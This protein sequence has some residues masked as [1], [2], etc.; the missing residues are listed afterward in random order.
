M[1]HNLIESRNHILMNTPHLATTTG[2]MVT[3][4]TDLAA[5]LTSVKANFLPV[6]EGSGDP[7]PTNVR[8]ITGWTGIKVCRA[9]KN[10]LDPAVKSG[11]SYVLDECWFGSDYNNNSRQLPIGNLFLP[12]NNYVLST[13]G[14]PTEKRVNKYD[15]TIIGHAYGNS[16][17]LKFTTTEENNRNIACYISVNSNQS[18]T[19]KNETMIE[20]GS[21]ATTFE[22]YSG[23]TISLDWSNEGTIYGGYVDLI[24]GNLMGLYKKVQLFKNTNNWNAWGTKLAYSTLI[25]NPIRKPGTIILSD[26]LTPIGGTIDPQKVTSKTEIRYYGVNTSYPQYLFMANPDQLSI[27]DWRQWAKETYP[28]ACIVYEFST[29]TL[30]TTLTPTQLKSLKGINN[31]W[32]NANSTVEATYWTH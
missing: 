22:P 19:W 7:S 30:I 20:L 10:L 11:P 28:D 29:P 27:S 18:D 14:V 3:F 5:P 12:P 21:A 1:A 32:S 4:N 26:T 8:P 25:D 13:T 6:Q 9:G 24:S 2:T 23:T 31:I 16:K 15:K 17:S